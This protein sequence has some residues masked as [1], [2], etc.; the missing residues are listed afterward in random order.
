MK[1]GGWCTPEPCDLDPWSKAYLG[2]TQPRIIPSSSKDID[3]EITENGLS[4]DSD[5]VQMTHNVNAADTF[6][7]IEKRIGEVG[8]S[9]WQVKCTKEAPIVKLAARDSPRWDHNEK[10]G[11]CINFEV[12]GSS[13]LGK[14]L[15]LHF[16][17]PKY[18]CRTNPNNREQNAINADQSVRESA[19][20][21][22]VVPVVNAT[23]LLSPK[24]SPFAS[25]LN[26]RRAQ[27]QI[28]PLR[29][30]AVP[31]PSPLLTIEEVKKNEAVPRRLAVKA[32]N[33]DDGDNDQCENE[34]GKTCGCNGNCN[35]CQNSCCCCCCC[36][37]S[38]SC[39]KCSKYENKADYYWNCNETKC[40]PYND[41]DDEP[42][43][44]DCSDD[45][46]INLENESISVLDSDSDNSDDP[47]SSRSSISDS[48]NGSHESSGDDS[49]DGSSGDED[50]MICSTF[51]YELSQSRN[52]LS[53]SQKSSLFEESSRISRSS[54]QSSTGGRGN[55]M[56]KNS[57]PGQRTNAFMKLSALLL[58]L[59]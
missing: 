9:V 43:P 13:Q 53:S 5:V 12:Q 4:P 10:G 20:H 27:R 47:D 56:H 38:G 19:L 31:E 32:V 24:D 29:H 44:E 55:G 28:K 21:V 26:H 42:V 54:S 25:V 14:T 58:L 51:T 6:F 37:G 7:L 41:E 35:N 49:S 30:K 46:S 36:C 39:D 45:S 48:S 8:P 59:L 34:G 11:D 22:E 57:A 18:S 17:S 33:E 52:C 3:T 15:L 40:I 23:T 1:T 16:N 2:W 50:V